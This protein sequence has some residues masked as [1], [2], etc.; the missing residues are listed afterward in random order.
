MRQS[1]E[2]APQEQE[3][4]SPVFMVPRGFLVN[5]TNYYADHRFGRRHPYARP[6]QAQESSSIILS[7]N[8]SDSQ[9]QI[10][11]WAYVA[12]TVPNHAWPPST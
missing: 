8:D 9:R 10:R 7:L 2:E 4:T 6:R 11:N 12:H 5:L 1:K 3:R